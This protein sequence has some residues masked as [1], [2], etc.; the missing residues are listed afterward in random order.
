MGPEAAMWHADEVSLR[1]NGDTFSRENNVERVD[2]MMDFLRSKARWIAGGI[3][4]LFLI[5]SVIPILS[6]FF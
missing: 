6:L 5:S 2:V 3:A 1:Y 4:L